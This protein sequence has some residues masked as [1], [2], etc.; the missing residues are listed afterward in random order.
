MDCL[1]GALV[2]F[3]PFK[4]IYYCPYFL[5]TLFTC[6]TS[7]YVNRLYSLTNPNHHFPFTRLNALRTRGEDGWKKRVEKK[8]DLVVTSVDKV[9]MREPKGGEGLARPTSIA[10]RLNELEFSKKIWRERVEE[11]DA[12]QFTTANKM[13]SSCKS[14]VV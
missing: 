1:M 13:A 10:D 11:N 5:S 7:Y 4:S 12:K 6:V 2:C 14:C 3:S 8:D 9:K